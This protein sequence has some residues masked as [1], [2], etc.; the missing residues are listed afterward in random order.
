MADAIQRQM[1]EVVSTALVSD[2]TP[3]HRRLLNFA[4]KSQ[5]CLALRC[6]VVAISVVVMLILISP[7][8]ILKFRYDQAQ[9]WRATSSICWFSISMV[10]SFMVLFTLV[11]PWLF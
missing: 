8:F 7:P 2:S 6:G 4:Q 3:I 11:L 10:A 9:P 1:S 5:E